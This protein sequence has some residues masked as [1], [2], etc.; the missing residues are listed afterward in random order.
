MI[1]MDSSDGKGGDGDGYGHSTK[2]DKLDHLAENGHP[3]LDSRLGIIKFCI[4]I[5]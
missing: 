3:G 2:M 4:P 1:F 5:S